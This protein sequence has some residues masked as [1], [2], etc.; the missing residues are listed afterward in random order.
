M[1]NKYSGNFLRSDPP[2]TCIHIF[3][4]LETL[5]EIAD[6]RTITQDHEIYSMDYDDTTYDRATKIRLRD[7]NTRS[8]NIST[9]IRLPLTRFALPNFNKSKYDHNQPNPIRGRKK[10][11]RINRFNR[12]PVGRQTLR[13]KHW[14]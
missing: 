8:R 9:K 7:N 1:S 11:S 2:E 13:S 3:C 4:V 10:G 12:P 14:Q 6:L 5:A